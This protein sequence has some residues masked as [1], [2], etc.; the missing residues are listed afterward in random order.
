MHDGGWRRIK[1][2]DLPVRLFHWILVA[3]IAAL[4]VTGEWGYMDQHMVLGQAVL[5]LVTWRIV[6]GLIG[7]DTARFARFLKGPAGVLAYARS[8]LTPTPLPTA[9]HNPVGGLM[10]VALLVLVLLQA[11]SGLF[12]TDDI[13]SEGPLIHLVSGKTAS[14]M[15]RIHHL[16]FN[17][18]LALVAIH[19]AAN[20][21]YLFVKKE[22]LIGPMVTGMKP[23]PPSIK[24]PALASP[25]VALF[26][27]VAL[28]AAWILFV[29]N[30]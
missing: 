14:L 15:T 2:W 28:A 12:A 20:L 5:V 4:Y 1:V 8:I 10:V 29:R 25:A 22:N 24:A 7:S 16:A 17:G 27:L 21:F 23:V 3:L 30:V 26:L 18:L 6:W 19:I 13:V 9:G 11:S